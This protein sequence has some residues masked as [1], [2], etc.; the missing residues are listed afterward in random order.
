MD[1][2]IGGG[3]VEGEAVLSEELSETVH[4]KEEGKGRSW[5]FEEISLPDS[6]P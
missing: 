5:K 2:V 1:N 3:R 4:Q 6:L